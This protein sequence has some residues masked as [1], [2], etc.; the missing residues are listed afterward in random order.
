MNKLDMLRRQ[1][2]LAQAALVIRHK[3]RNQAIRA[4]E[5]VEKFIKETEKKIE[6]YMA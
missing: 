1:L 5:R 3:Q 4:C 2:K 6:I